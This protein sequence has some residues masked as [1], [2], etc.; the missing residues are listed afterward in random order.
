MDVASHPRGLKSKFPLLWQLG[1]LQC[2]HSDSHIDHL[3]CFNWFQRKAKPDTDVWHPVTEISR[4]GLTHVGA[5]CRL[6]IWC[7]FKLT[8]LVIFILRED[9]QTF[10]RMCA[11]I[12]DNVAVKFFHMWEHEFTGTI[13]PI[14]PMKS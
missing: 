12:A 9:W 14:I 8:I 1:K 11:Q 3:L 13:F 5:L 7:H 2:L 6:I 4:A 10:L